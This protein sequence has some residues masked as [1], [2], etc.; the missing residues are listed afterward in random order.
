MLI[1]PKLGG[2]RLQSEPNKN[3]LVA[4]SISLTSN[5]QFNSTLAP[6]TSSWLFDL[7]LYGKTPIFSPKLSF[8]VDKNLQKCGILTLP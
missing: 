3:V 4:K 1:W 2:V 6:K 7:L 8:S 5:N